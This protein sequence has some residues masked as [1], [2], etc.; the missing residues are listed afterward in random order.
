MNILN[1]L[2]RLFFFIIKQRTKKYTRNVCFKQE[3]KK[4]LFGKEKMRFI[5]TFTKTKEC[6]SE[7]F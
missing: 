6:Y 4:Y 1:D 7:F 3:R 5:K 2:R